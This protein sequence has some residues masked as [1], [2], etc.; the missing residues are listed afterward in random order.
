M[1][2]SEDVKEK[3]GR[4]PAGLVSAG[5][6]LVLVL[7]LGLGLA[8]GGRWVAERHGGLQG[9][10]P[11]D[12]PSAARVGRVGAG[13]PPGRDRAATAS[14][15]T[16]EDGQDMG[17]PRDRVSG[18]QREA[19]RPPLG[20]SSLAALPDKT[21]PVSPAAPPA[22]EPGE[23]RP[24]LLFRPVATAAGRIEAAGH[25]V[26][27]EGIEV[28]DPS[29]QC[30][31]GGGRT[32][33]CGMVSRAAF[34][35]WLRGRAVECTVAP[36][37]PAAPVVSPCRLGRQD[38][39][40]WLVANGLVAAVPE[41]AYAQAGAEAKAA[42]RG[43]FGDRPRPVAETLEARS[44]VLAAPGSEQAAV[45]AAAEIIGAGDPASVEP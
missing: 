24:T 22:L 1:T 25:V 30:Q 16:I 4:R 19:P 39:A 28:L 9:E 32:W 10:T 12:A 33:P 23:P 42:R 27:L 14:V 43:I 29:A 45:D 11:R 20:P 6:G 37:P 21:V 15:R 8:S 35:S 3:T 31:A 5:G 40:R 34:R 13:A 44:S 17:L 38:A 36:V 26:D 2:T 7:L 18:W 41:G